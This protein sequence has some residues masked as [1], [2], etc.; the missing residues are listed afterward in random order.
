MPSLCRP[1]LQSEHPPLTHA[2]QNVPFP[3]APLYHVQG[4]AFPPP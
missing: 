4:F 2:T 1:F 3:S